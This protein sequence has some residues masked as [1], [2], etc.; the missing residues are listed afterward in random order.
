MTSK[1]QL[2]N[3][4]YEKLSIKYDSAVKGGHILFNGDSA[5]NEIEKI[6]ITDENDK[7]NT[8]IDVQLTLLKSLIHRPEIG[9]TTKNENDLNPFLKPEPE[10][11]IIDD[12]NNTNEFKI[13]FNKFPVVPRHFML[14]TKEFKSQNTPLSPNELMAT[15]QILQALKNQ[16][17][18][19]D[20]DWFAFYNC[21]PESGASQPHKHIQFMTL[22]SREQFKP[23]AETLFQEEKEE[24]DDDGD[25]QEQQ[26]QQQ[27]KK[28]E[29]KQ[30]KHLPFAHFFVPI[31]N[32]VVID[33]SEEELAHLFSSILQ[34]TLTELRETDQTHIS[35]NFIMTLNYM[36]MIP[37]S[38]GKYED[39]LGIN[40]C[41]FQGLILCKNQELF[42]FVKSIG[43]LEI[44][45]QVGL[46]NSSNKSTTEYDY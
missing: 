41:G 16:P 23:Y 35:Y 12:Y 37:R 27:V 15:Y 5:I 45:K 4:F 46:P 28:S 39:K 22:P 33:E 3:D 8:T 25:D 24:E 29:P 30:N 13:V 36:L 19:Q 7:E 9:T 42:E 1:Y 21:G 17:P 43:P 18:N 31:T 34:K 44:L 14:V 26:Q 10:L 20:Q 32:E 11:T 38:K 2:S 6:I 40:S